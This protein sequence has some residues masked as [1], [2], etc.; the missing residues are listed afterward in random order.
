MRTRRR[1]RALQYCHSMLRRS[2]RP[3]QGAQSPPPC[4]PWLPAKLCRCAMPSSASGLTD[5]LRHAPCVA[6]AFAASM[7]LILSLL[8]PQHNFLRRITPNLTCALALFVDKRQCERGAFNT[9]G[10]G[11][12]RL[13]RYWQQP[14]SPG[15]RQPVPY[16]CATRI[17]SR[18]SWS[19]AVL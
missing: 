1:F 18:A 19:S 13:S 6:Q 7:R 12:A 2:T 10:R 8:S 9:V 11:R 4:E 5:R 16:R 17:R 15:C 14:R 3:T